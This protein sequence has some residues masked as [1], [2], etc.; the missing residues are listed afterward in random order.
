MCK[1]ELEQQLLNYNRAYREGKPLMSDE[2]FDRLLDQ[3]KSEF[4]KAYPNF[5]KTLFESSGEVR[6][7]FPVGSLEDRKSTRLNSSH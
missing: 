5:R 1:E 4:P 2:E 7:K 6:H 3:Y